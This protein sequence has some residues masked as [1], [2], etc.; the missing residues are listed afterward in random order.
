LSG[1]CGFPEVSGGKA[2]NRKNI[3]GKSC[4]GI[5]SGSMSH[6][7]GAAFRDLLT[8][9][10]TIP[11]NVVFKGIHVLNFVLAVA[12]WDSGTNIFS[13]GKTILPISI[14]LGKRWARYKSIH[15]GIFHM[16]ISAV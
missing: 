13:R 12:K 16:Q 4:A 2:M 8:A 11:G 5:I 9:S 3:S 14:I 1:E 15:S 6:S 7:N 10:H